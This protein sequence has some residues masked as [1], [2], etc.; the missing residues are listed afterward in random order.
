MSFPSCYSYNHHH[1]LVRVAQVPGSTLYLCSFF[2]LSSCRNAAGPDSRTSN[3]PFLLFSQNYRTTC[4]R[5]ISPTLNGQCMPP[6]LV[7]SCPIQKLTVPEPRARR[8]TSRIFSTLSIN[9]PNRSCNAASQ[10]RR[11][12][13]PVVEAFAHH[14]RRSV[15]IFPKY[16][17]PLQF[18][19]VRW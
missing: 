19:N 2:R 7:A 17:F 6:V 18:R 4:S 12:I 10:L 11:T 9:N 16:L 3:F 5:S 15:R 8:S 14:L 13:R 1:F